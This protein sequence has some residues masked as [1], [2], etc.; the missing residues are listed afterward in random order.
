MRRNRPDP[1]SRRRAGRGR[2]QDA[3]LSR[4]SSR[5]KKPSAGGSSSASSRRST[6]YAA[7]Q[8][9][10]RA[11]LAHR[12]RPHRDR[13]RRRPSCASTICTS[14]Y[15]CVKERLHKVLAHAGV[16]SRRAAERMIR[17][18]R[19][20]VNGAARRR[21]GH[22]GRPRPR[23]HR[24]RRPAARSRSRRRT[25]Y[26]ALNKP[27]GVVSTAHD[28]EGR[29]TVVE[30][31]HA[32][33][34][35]LSRRSPGYRF[36]RA[37]AAHRRRRADVS[38]DP[39]A[40]RR[41][42]RSTTSTWRVAD[43]GEP[44]LEQLRARRRARGWPGARGARAADRARRRASALVRVVLI[45]GRQRQVRRMLAAARLRGGGAAAGADRTAAARRAEPGQHASSS[46]AR[47]TR[48]APRRTEHELVASCARLG[49]SGL[50]GVTHEHQPRAVCDRARRTRGIGQEQRRTRRRARLGLS[51]TSTRA[52]C[53][54]P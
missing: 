3:R 24:G 29:P 6:T 51:A 14:V 34:A 10:A 32:S 20:R 1:Q 36:R 40:L 33:A 47:S 30:L 5:P 28:P 2:G 37:G 7:G 17:D 46:N 8:R 22:P 53:I 49:A 13:A 31:V 43:F 44:Q 27:L 52:C 25:T 45:E 41:S 42:K 23:P 15:P 21:A 19:V 4:T 50:R 48:C 38:A 26:V 9:P 18:R 35:R 39:R 11:A 12:R 16:A 54:A